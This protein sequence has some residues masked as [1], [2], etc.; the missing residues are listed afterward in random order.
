MRPVVVDLRQRAEQ[1][2]QQELARTLRYMGDDIDDEVVAQLNHLSRSLVNRLL[3][4]PTLRLRE[5]AHN[6]QAD[7]YA[8]AIRDLFD[9]SEMQDLT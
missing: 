6:G 2:R 3:H 8:A 5:V 9:L 7:A 1:I 4:S